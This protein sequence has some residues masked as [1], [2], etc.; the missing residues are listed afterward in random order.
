[1]RAQ[2]FEMTNAL[3]ELEAAG[4]FLDVLKSRYGNGVLLHLVGDAVQELQMRQEAVANL[5]SHEKTDVFVDQ[6]VASATAPSP[7][8]APA[9]AIPAAGGPVARDEYPNV[10]DPASAPTSGP[11]AQP[12]PEFVQTCVDFLRKQDMLE[13]RYA[14]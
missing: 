3:A 7:T 9:P 2:T 10:P 6:G 11:Y 1:M 5:K 14:Q 12:N 8:F 13:Q 4:T